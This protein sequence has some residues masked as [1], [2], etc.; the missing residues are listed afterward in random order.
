MKRIQRFVGLAVAALLVTAG[1]ASAAQDHAKKSAAPG[2]D[3]KEKAMMDAMMKA[4][5]PGAEHKMLA[6]MAGTWD[7][8]VRMWMKPGAPPEESA[9]TSEATSI[10]GGR[11]LEE[12][13]TGTAM[14][15]PFTG[16]GITGYDNVQKKYV[17]TWADSMSTGIMTSTG[18]ADGNKMTMSGQMADPMTGKMS[19]IKQ[20]MTM[21]D[22][23]HH[24][25][26][27]W[28]AGPDGKSFKMMEIEY[29]RKK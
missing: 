18:R 11:Y 25:F 14:G 8:K 29:T 26:E 13:F 10:M 7:A 17:S 5:T 4:G 6:D 16:Q 9:G 20:V 19:N 27:M 3:D 21:T 2:G 28:A 1:L 23:D 24:K 15:Q 12:K 22:N